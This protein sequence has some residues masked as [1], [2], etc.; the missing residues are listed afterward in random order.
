M[1]KI[2][3]IA[4]FGHHSTREDEPLFKDVFNTTQILARHGYTIVQGGGGGV[5]LA[6]GLGAK[7]G[8][9]K[10]IGVTYNPTK[11]EGIGHEHFEGVTQ[12]NPMDEEIVTK[13]YIERTLT[14]MDLADL[15]LVFNG[16]SGTVSEFGMAWGLAKIH[17]GHH[18]PL[19]LYGEFWHDIMESFGSN[20]MISETS[21]SVYAIVSRPHD[22][23]KAF[24]PLCANAA[25][26]E[27]LLVKSLEEGPT[28]EEKKTI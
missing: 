15:Y 17:F 6:A 11:M 8:G 16:D 9:G 3:K 27:P 25:C 14:M 1:Y 23:V 10:T 20:M 7:A 18:K 12:E 4:V 26:F 21:L 5:M 28:A 19:I 24:E 22:V 2:E 13:N